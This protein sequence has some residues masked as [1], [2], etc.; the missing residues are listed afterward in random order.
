MTL[1]CKK[2]QDDTFTQGEENS[3]T[4]LMILTQRQTYN[5]HDQH[6][7]DGDDQEGPLVGGQKGE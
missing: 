6:N 2:K 4:I 1:I 3:P 5:H 7:H